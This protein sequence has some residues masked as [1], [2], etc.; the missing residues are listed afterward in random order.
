MKTIALPVLIALFLFAPL[1]GSGLLNGSDQLAIGGS[2]TLR[3]G[4]R[5]AGNLTLLFV[6][7]T[8]EDGA[9]VDGRIVSVSSVLDVQG[10]VNG[11]V[12]SIDSDMTM[13][14]TAQMNGTSKEIRGIPYVILLPQIARVGGLA[15]QK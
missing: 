6:Q 7:F 13:R 2:Y 11:D 8:L 5:I 14:A 10:R 12:L 15:Q 4:E 1:T 9:A 3:N